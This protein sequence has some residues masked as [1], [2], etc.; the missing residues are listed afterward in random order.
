MVSYSSEAPFVGPPI[1]VNSYFYPSGSVGDGAYG[2]RYI[3]LKSA[4]EVTRVIYRLPDM[5]GS[6]CLA[7]PMQPGQQADDGEAWPDVVAGRRQQWVELMGNI[8]KGSRDSSDMNRQGPALETVEAL[9]DRAGRCRQ[10][11]ERDQPVLVV[12]HQGRRSIR[13]HVLREEPPLAIVELLP[14]PMD[15]AS[16][17]RPSAARSHHG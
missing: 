17:Q 6:A 2:T 14:A 1:I 12:H 13:P 9:F 3:K 10:G 8:H 5:S 16:T 7:M 4:G 11:L 15:C